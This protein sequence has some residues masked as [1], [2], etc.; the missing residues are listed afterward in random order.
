[1]N[2]DLKKYSG[3]VERVPKKWGDHQ[4]GKRRVSLA[5][6][7]GSRGRHSKSSSRNS[8]QRFG[9][10]SPNKRYARHLLVLNVSDMTGFSMFRLASKATEI[11]FPRLCSL[12]TSH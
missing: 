2:V 3:L 4:R 6:R 8:D 11:S 5:G 9:P 10:G 7:R 12:S 1:M